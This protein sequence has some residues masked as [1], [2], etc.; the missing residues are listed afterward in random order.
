MSKP[1]ILGSR[2]SELAMW[3]T[4]MVEK[5]LQQ[6]GDK[7]IIVGIKTQ[8]DKDQHSELHTLGGTGVFTKAIDQALLEGTIDVGVHSLKDYP[9]QAPEGLTLKA[10][11]PRDFYHDVFIPGG[12]GASFDDAMHVASGSPRRKAQW[13]SKYPHHTFSNLRGNMQKRLE[14]IASFDGGIVSEAG[15]RRLN[16]LPAQAMTLDWMVPAPGQGVVALVVRSDDTYT[17]EAVSKLNDKATEICTSIERSFMQYLEA[18]CAA[19]L[20]AI[21]QISNENIEFT[22]VLNSLDGQKEVRI[23]RDFPISEAAGAGQRLAKEVLAMG[24]RAIMDEI[25]RNA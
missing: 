10:V 1:I 17:S 3:Q 6:N 9:T 21:A 16:I 2:T 19:P 20:G 11:L 22:G 18:G 13:W 8:G 23:Q 14:R 12:S 15:L 4:L 7:T 24:G 25:R 5:A